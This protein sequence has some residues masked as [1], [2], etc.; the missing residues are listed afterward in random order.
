MEIKEHHAI[1]KP[2]MEALVEHFLKELQ[3]GV[4]E[5]GWNISVEKKNLNVARK[6]TPGTDV[7]RLR[8]VGDLPY[9]IEVVDTVLNNVAIRRAW[10]KGIV[11]VETIEELENGLLVVYMSTLC[12][13]GITNR[14]FL[15]LRI[16]V[17]NNEAGTK[18]I[19]DKSVK[20]PARP[21]AKGY[22]RANTIFS[23]LVLTKKQ[24]QEGGKIIEATQYAAIS[25]VDVCGELPKLILNAVVCKA[26]ADWF[27]NLEKACIAYTTGKLQP[28]VTHPT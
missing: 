5:G 26:T 12:P 2:E 17:N 24:L 16:Q 22:I 3:E 19:L 25:Q 28:V 6:R 14:D 18:I 21:Q 1:A 4:V 27:A 10:D 13:P 9:S 11:V 23:G 15:H 8:M 20:H 7:H